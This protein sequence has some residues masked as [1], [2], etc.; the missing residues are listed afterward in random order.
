M[1]ICPIRNSRIV[2][3]AQ[4]QAELALF[5]SMRPHYQKKWPFQFKADIYTEVGI[6]EIGR[7]SDVIVKVS[8]KKIF[9]VECKLDN[10]TTV[11][12]QARDHLKWVDY[13]YICFFA[14]AYFP[15]RDIVN[16][17]KWG[18]GLILWRPGVFVEAVH[19]YQNT[20]KHGLKDKHLRMLVN[21]KLMD[22][23]PVYKYNYES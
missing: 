18:I 10:Y 7:I 17:V 23:K 3:E 9:N 22:R 12:Q 6:P 2:T 21:S 19:S 20:Y 4:M 14:D 5:L 8:E 15:A 11:I 16:L 13:S 1:R